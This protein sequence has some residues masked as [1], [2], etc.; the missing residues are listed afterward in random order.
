MTAMQER[1]KRVWAWLDRAYDA[2]F[3]LVMPPEIAADLTVILASVP[4]FKAMHP[5][6]GTESAPNA[7]PR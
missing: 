4:E 5:R 1:T 2:N 3:K 6:I 7:R